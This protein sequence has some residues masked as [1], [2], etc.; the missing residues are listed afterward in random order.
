[1]RLSEV[2]TLSD[3]SLG[4]LIGIVTRNCAAGM[5]R[6]AARV[7]TSAILASAP[8]ASALGRGSCVLGSDKRIPFVS[9]PYALLGFFADLEKLDC[10]LLDAP[11]P[12]C[13]HLAA[14]EVRQTAIRVAVSRRWR[15][16]NTTLIIRPLPFAGLRARD[17]AGA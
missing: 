6:T 15:A 17:T 7:L 5:T 12:L 1:M 16:Q 14:K 4:R 3:V 11:A 9:Q 2:S 8:L 13:G 10:R